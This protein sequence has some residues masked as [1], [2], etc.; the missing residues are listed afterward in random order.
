MKM[1]CTFCEKLLKNNANPE[2]EVCMSCRH[3]LKNKK[4]IRRFIV[5]MMK[6]IHKLKDDDVK[7]ISSAKNELDQMFKIL[8]TTEYRNEKELWNEISGFAEK[9]KNPKFIAVLVN[10]L[11]GFGDHCMFADTSSGSTMMNLEMEMHKSTT[12]KKPQK[13]FDETTMEEWK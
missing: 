4:R 11:V 7:F 8:K 3:E 12:P 10:I 1:R 9:N 13:Q 2:T 5:D 6:Y